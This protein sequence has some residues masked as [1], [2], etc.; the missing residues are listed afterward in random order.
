[1]YAYLILINNY[2]FRS[3]PIGIIAGQLQID[4]D[5]MSTHSHLIQLLASTDNNFNLICV[6]CSSKNG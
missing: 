3:T 6:S 5:E 4:A 2:I 1:M